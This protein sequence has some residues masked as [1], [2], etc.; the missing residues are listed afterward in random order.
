MERNGKKY[1]SMI[2]GLYNISDKAIEKMETNVERIDD[3]LSKWAWSDVEKEISRY[4]AYKN[5]K[6][7]PRVGQ[8]IALL[9]SDPSVQELLPTTPDDEPKCPYTR[10]EKIQPVFYDTCL[11]MHTHG[12]WVSEYF[13]KVKGIPSGCNMYTKTTV[14]DGFK[15]LTA[16][17]HRDDAD[18]AIALARKKYAYEFAPFDSVRTLNKAEELA[19]TVTLGLFELS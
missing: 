1:I 15:E 6:T 7:F 19:L 5:D 17:F 8:I 13:A 14:K 12:Y 2:T 10:I 18:R 16:G 9:M 11:W 3:A 4:F